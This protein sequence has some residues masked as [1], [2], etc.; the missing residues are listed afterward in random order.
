[1]LSQYFIIPY[2]RPEKKTPQH[3][4]FMKQLS[5]NPAVWW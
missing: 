3:D 1:M 4:S 5:F 2:L